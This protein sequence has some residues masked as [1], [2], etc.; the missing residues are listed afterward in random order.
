MKAA[1]ASMED[2]LQAAG[3]EEVITID[4]YAHLVGGCRMATRRRTAWSTR[5]PELRR[6][7]PVHHRR[8]RPA[9]PRVPPTRP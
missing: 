4:R 2:I 3:A 8:Q 6:P 1:Q 5:P 9:H 7:Q